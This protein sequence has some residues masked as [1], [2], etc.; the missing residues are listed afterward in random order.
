MTLLFVHDYPY[1][2]PS[3]SPHFL[4]LCVGQK[5]LPKVE[6]QIQK[7]DKNEIYFIGVQ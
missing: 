7:L 4:R 6:L 5:R 2:A 1:P 3:M